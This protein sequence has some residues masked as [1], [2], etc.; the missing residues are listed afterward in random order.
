MFKSLTDSRDMEMIAANKK[1]SMTVLHKILADIR[2]GSPKSY[3]NTRV[4][5]NIFPEDET[6]V[7]EINNEIV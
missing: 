3:A 2:H 4:R 7:Y 5:T 1:I 6:T